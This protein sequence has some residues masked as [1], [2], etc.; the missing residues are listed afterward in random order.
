MTTKYIN[1]YMLDRAYGGP[2]EGGWWFT[3]GE[4]V[5]SFSYRSERVKERLLRRVQCVVDA[6][7][8]GRTSINSVLSAGEFAV[9]QD[10]HPAEAFPKE[11]PYYS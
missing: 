7:N 6:L 11:R 1:V 5:R 8:E 4:P 3:Y 9:R 2:E 10:G